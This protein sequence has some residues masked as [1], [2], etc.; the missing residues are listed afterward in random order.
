MHRNVSPFVR[1]GSSAAMHRFAPASNAS[2]PCAAGTILDTV[3]P[4]F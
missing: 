1:T 3:R 4:V 2:G